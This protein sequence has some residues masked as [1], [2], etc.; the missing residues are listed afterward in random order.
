MNP[1]L[2]S[3]IKRLTA[4]KFGI[5]LH[6][7]DSCGSG[8]YFSLDERNDEAAR[9]IEDYFKA[10]NLKVSVAPSGLTFSVE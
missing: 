4:E 2:I 7:H 1:V 8:M 9:F 3:E 10:R 5:H 6:Y